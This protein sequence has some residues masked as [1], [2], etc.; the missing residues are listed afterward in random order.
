M[1]PFL[2]A[3]HHTYQST[4]VNY[5][6]IAAGILINAFTVVGLCIDIH[7]YSFHTVVTG[8][9]PVLRNVFSVI[10][11]PCHPLVMLIMLGCMPS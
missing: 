2:S 6:T 5:I 4:S 11:I 3:I 1:I 7:L 10:M 8:A 9:V